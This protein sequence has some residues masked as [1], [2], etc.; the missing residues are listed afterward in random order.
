[1]KIWPT[2]K[3]LWSIIAPPQMKNTALLYQAN[4][5][6]ATDR[7]EGEVL[8]KV[9]TSFDAKVRVHRQR[10]IQMWH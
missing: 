8:N 3:L 10:Q 4:S 5:R 2:S 9:S 6:V 1:M 7:F